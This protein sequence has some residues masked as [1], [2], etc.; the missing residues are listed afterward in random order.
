M[1]SPKVLGLKDS[2]MLTR[3]LVRLVG[4]TDQGL[5]LFESHVHANGHDEDRAIGDHSD[6]VSKFQASRVQPTR[7]QGYGL[8]AAKLQ[9]LPQARYR[10]GIR[11]VRKF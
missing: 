2:G 1:T 11:F 6:L 5:Q 8:A 10:H 9:D 7:R 4:Y 3:S